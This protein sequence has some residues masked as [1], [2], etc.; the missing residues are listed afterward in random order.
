MKK[1]VTLLAL[2]ALVYFPHSLIA[3]SIPDKIDAILAGSAVA[4]NTWTVF[5]QNADGAVTYYQRNPD[6]GLA[7]A[8]NT[9]LYTCSAAWGLLGTNA[10]FE[11]RVYGNGALAGGVLTGDLNLVSEHDIT[12]NSDVFS[13]PRAA[14]D[15]IALQLKLGGV[16]NV[17]GN[18]QCYG[19]CFYDLN[20]TDASNHDSA[21]QLGYNRTAATNFVAALV[22]QG[23]TVAGIPMGKTGF[24]PPGTLLYTHRSTD[25]TYNGQPLRMDVACTP[26]LKVSHNVMADALLRHISYKINGLDTFAAGAGQVLPWLKNVAGVSTNGMVMNDG[27]GL[28]HGNKFSGR[29]TVTLIRY[30]LG[31]FPSFAP[32]LPI[33]CGDGTLGGR[34][35]G[36]DGSGKVHAKTGS[37]STSIALSG[38]IDNKYDGRRY[39]F[40]FISNNNSGIDQTNTRDAIDAAVVLLGAQGVAISPQLL[41]VTNKGNNS[42]A[43][44]WSDEKF[45]RTGYR[46]YSSTDGTNFGAP[47]NVGSAVQTYTDAGLLPGTKK[48]YRVS[49]VG[50]GGESPFSRVYGAQTANTLSRILVVDGFD[51][52]QFLRTDNPNA[53]NHSFSAIAGQSISGAA[54]DTAN[55][56][57]VTNGTVALSNYQAVI[58][59]LGT[60]STSN[61]TFEASEE[62]AVT[63]YLNGGGNLFVNGAEIGWDLD[64]PSGP[65]AADRNFYHNQLRAVFSADD[66]NIYAFSP[67][68]TGIFT[69]NANGGFDNGTHGTYN[70]AFPDVLTPT[71]GSV[72]AILYS[73]GL[74]GAA[75]VQ[76]D[77]SLGGGKVVN[78]GFPFETITSSTVR[79]AYMSDVL[80]FFGVLPPPSLMQPQVAFNGTNVVLSWSASAGLKYRV[81]SKNN[82]TDPVWQTVGTDI[83]ATNTLATQKDAGTTGIPQRFYRIL[84]VN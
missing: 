57:M 21:N 3:Q 75:G 65:S 73:G 30:M 41:C 16:T 64:R 1:V 82:L 63:D 7:P 72:A 80:R 39:L 78:W 60:E 17:T 31:N 54:F 8:S 19:V 2:V 36:T 77:G 42:I 20:S 56:M 14:L 61:R 23:I 10:Y 71:N 81:Q 51:R 15:R 49:V 83:T 11:T 9:K 70:V 46:I 67:V 4:A 47:I 58:W 34:F 40:S 25:L 29:Q 45:I 44:R 24:A 62:A 12:W 53:T 18:V 5:I 26:M 35:C 38:Y 6:T 59:M 79:D 37:L 33:G 28:S 68:A 22:A 84:L 32:A 74:G 69:N 76:Y 13:N 55:H 43:L 52:W 50:S 66:A 27:S 48:F